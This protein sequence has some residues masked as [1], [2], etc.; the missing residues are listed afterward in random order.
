MSADR[1]AAPSGPEAPSWPVRALVA[2]LLL[3]LAGW[4][5]LTIA[6]RDLWASQDGSMLV[7]VFAFGTV[8]IVVARRQPRNGVG[9]ILAGVSLVLLFS[10]DSKLYSVLDYRIHTG[11]LP[12]G[13]IALDFDSVG[14]GALVLGMLAVLLFPDGRLQGRWRRWV[15]V[16]VAVGVAFVI[17]QIGGEATLHLGRHIAVDPRG[18]PAGSSNQT[19]W[20]GASFLLMPI[21]VGFWAAFIGRQVRSWRRAGGVQ[22]EQIKWLMS[23]AV[24]TL[25]GAV[26]LLASASGHGTFRVVAAVATVAIASFPLAVGVGILKYRLYE[27]D[28]LI[29]RTLSY[30]IIT[31]LLAGVFIGIVVLATDVLPF[32]SP[33][34][35]AASTLTAAALFNPLR[36]RVQHQVDRRFNRSSYDAEAVVTAFTLR[37]RDAVDLDTVRTDLME[38]VDEAIQPAHASVWLRPAARP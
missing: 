8:G 5:A 15:W 22:R 2:G 3:M 33:I 21:L 14:P 1:L 7:N 23:G 30:V 25:V 27:I 19:G 24:M 11:G 17:G 34:A 31:G 36:L 20:W 38:A 10:L 4:I 9:W 28:R 35:V 32:S 26:S 18:K 29:S 6:T 13:R 16:Y 37:L 12:L